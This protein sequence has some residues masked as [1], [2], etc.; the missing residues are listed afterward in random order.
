MF[1]IISINIVAMDLS[2][3]ELINFIDQ[4]LTQAF[5]VTIDQQIKNQNLITK[6]TNEVFRQEIK[7][8]WVDCFYPRKNN[9]IK[10]YTIAALKKILFGQVVLITKNKSIKADPMCK[11]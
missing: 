8:N 2:N 9:D 1:L 6:Q 10:N 3:P 5:I 7:K 11:G 4:T